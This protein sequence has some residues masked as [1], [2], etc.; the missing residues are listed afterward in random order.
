M[1]VTVVYSIQCTLYSCTGNRYNVVINVG[2]IIGVSVGV[3]KGVNVD[4]NTYVNVDVN[5]EC[6]T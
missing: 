2:A 5:A 3:N 4:G 6:I 1:L